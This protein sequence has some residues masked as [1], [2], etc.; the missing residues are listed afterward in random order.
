[1]VVTSE[2]RSVA[3]LIVNFRNLRD[4]QSCL[5]ALSAATVEPAF[6]V[7]ICENGGEVAFEELKATLAGPYGPCS[8]DPPTDLPG[9]ASTTSERLVEVEHMTLRGR[10]SSVWVARADH[11]LGYAGAINALIDRLRLCSDWHAIWILNP[12]AEPNSQRPR[13]ADGILR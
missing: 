4:I 10:G 13:G 6:Q 11:N 1:M 3:V 12:D 7:F 8:Q 2:V 5:T 9:W